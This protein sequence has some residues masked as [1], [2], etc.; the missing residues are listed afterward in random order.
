MREQ[1]LYPFVAEWL[2]GFLKG[3]Y[4]RAIDI[5]AEDTSRSSVARFLS[6]HNLLHFIP[7]GETLDI[8]VDITGAALVKAKTQHSVKLA[9]VEVKLGVVSLR[10]LS[11]IL[12]YAKVTLPSHA[13][14]VSP[15]GWSPTI[16]WLVRDFR[17]LDVLE[18]ARGKLIVVAKWDHPSNSV[19]PGEVLLP[20]TL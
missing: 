6:Q 16:Q 12:G 17:R 1:D 2:K 20:G 13:F 18:Y 14:I 15:K 19:R 8:P 7:W 4:P 9:I 10:D 11:Q 3:H 5:Y